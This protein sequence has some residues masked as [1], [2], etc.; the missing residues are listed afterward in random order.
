MIWMLYA[1]LGVLLLAVGF[2][3]AVWGEGVSWLQVV[4]GS[5]LIAMGIEK[6]RRG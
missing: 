1:V 6:R 5:I 4:L 3:G 2:A